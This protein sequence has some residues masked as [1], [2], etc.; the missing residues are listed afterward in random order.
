MAL[1]CKK[2]KNKVIIFCPCQVFLTI[3]V[4]MKNYNAKLKKEIQQELA[5][6]WLYT[7]I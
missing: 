3:V 7:K 1:K 2:L 4:K 5:I 6:Q